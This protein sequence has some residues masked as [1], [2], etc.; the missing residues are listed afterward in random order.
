MTF[1]VLLN[2]PRKPGLSPHEFK[3]HWENVHVPLLKQL[4]GYDFPLSHT[5]HYVERNLPSSPT[6]P[7]FGPALDSSEIAA[8][9]T[10]LSLGDVDGVAVL[11]FANKEHYERFMGKLAD[12][13]KRKAI[14]KDLESFVD[15]NANR[16]VF[17]GETRATGRDGG[18]VGWRFVGS[19]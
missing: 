8:A 19:V 6:S 14:E 17:A 1:T 7:M 18:M 16:A 13:K 9:N 3:H 15:V 12:G 5:R 10:L 2:V 11:T 4:V